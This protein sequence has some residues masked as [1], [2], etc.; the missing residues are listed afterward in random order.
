MT[1]DEVKQILIIIEIAFPNF[2][3][4]VEKKKA[5]VNLWER[6]LGAYDYKAV[7]EAV[8]TFINTSGSAF[9]PSLPQIIEM[10]HKPT[11]L[12]VLTEGEAWALVSKALRNSAYHSQEEFDKLPAD[13]QK[14]VGAPSM[15]YAWATDEGYNE[16]VVMSNFQR[17]YNVVVKRRLEEARMPQVIKDRIEQIKTMMIEEK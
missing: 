10:L 8:D 16:S 1:R 2:V 11:E 3:V 15:L 6:Q 4:P 9:A 5:M 17:A 12:A 14:A 13:V 7:E